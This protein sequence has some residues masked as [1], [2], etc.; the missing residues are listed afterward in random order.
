MEADPKVRKGSGGTPGGP[1][2][3]GRPTQRFGR[4]MVAHPEVREG[5]G[6]SPEVRKAHPKVEEG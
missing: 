6:C 4:G 2:G 3:V 5:P 1:R